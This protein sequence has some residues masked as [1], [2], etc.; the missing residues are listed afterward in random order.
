MRY[1]IATELVE[2]YLIFLLWVQ[3][4]ILGLSPEKI[5]GFTDGIASGVW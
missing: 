5:P 3:V 4:R 1:D 2:S